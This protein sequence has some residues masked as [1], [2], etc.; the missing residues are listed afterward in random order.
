MAQQAEGKDVGIVE[1]RS[2]RDHLGGHCVRSRQ[3]AAVQRA[4]ERGNEQDPTGGDIRVCVREHA[5]DP[6][7]PSTRVRVFTLQQQSDRQPRTATSGLLDV[8]GTKGERVG[9][10]P[11]G[12]AV[13][14]VPGHI[15]RD[16][17][18]LVVVGAGELRRGQVRVRVGPRRAG[19]R[20]PTEFDRTSHR[21]QCRGPSVAGRGV[22]S[23]WTGPG[24]QAVDI[25]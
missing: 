23:H 10:F 24:V 16:G 19:E 14:V 21:H 8:V 18:E 3:I 7:Q 1:T 22:A 9:A 25:E 4:E 2:D 20:F 5:L 13:V 15:G 11:R 6:R 17:V 12:R